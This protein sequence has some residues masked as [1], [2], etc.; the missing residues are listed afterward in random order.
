MA[1]TG[2]IVFE[3]RGVPKAGPVEWVKQKL[4][5][6]YTT[7][8]RLEKEFR[9]LEKTMGPL[10][11]SQ[12]AEVAARIG[13]KIHNK[14][15]GN[16]VKDA[17]GAVLVVTTGGVLIAKPELRAKLSVTLGTAS[18]EAGQYMSKNFGN[19][20]ARLRTV[21]NEGDKVVFFKRMLAGMAEG[22]QKATAATS[23]RTT[24]FFANRTMNAA[25][26]V[27][28][29][30]AKLAS[31]VLEFQNRPVTSDPNVANA[32]ADKMKKAH[33]ALLGNQKVLAEETAKKVKFK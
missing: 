28:E 16:V 11:D 26:K 12:R 13:D 22:A 4:R 32:F 27:G 17:I 19:A 2:G 23:S 31:K 18:M 33:T 24:E 29:K 6:R 7:K 20:A 15:V 1:E 10:T 3:G 14:V 21:A 25:S 30:T 5:E 9:S 8:G